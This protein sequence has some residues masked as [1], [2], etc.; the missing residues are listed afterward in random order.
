MRAAVNSGEAKALEMLVRLFDW[1]DGCV[2]QP[3]KDILSLYEHSQSIETQISNILASMDQLAS[4]RNEL[5]KIA[6]DIE[7][8]KSVSPV[9]ILLR[10]DNTLTIPSEYVHFQGL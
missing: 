2:P 10:R 3:T 1:L 6:N 4:K 7:K 5:Q 9:S 8:A